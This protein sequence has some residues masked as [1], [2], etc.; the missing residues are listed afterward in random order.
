MEYKW[1]KTTELLP[2]LTSEGNDWQFS[3][4]VLICTNSLSDN[5]Y[6]QVAFCKH[7]AD[8]TVWVNPIS[9]YVIR[10]EDVRY[11][12]EIEPAPDTDD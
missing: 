2:S 12:R 10:D 6:Y 7:K 3:H 1:R 5:Y 4:N 11:W 9:G 8:K